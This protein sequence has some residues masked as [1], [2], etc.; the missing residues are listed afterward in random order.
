M[1]QSTALAAARQELA[2]RKARFL[3]GSLATAWPAAEPAAKREPRSTA[4]EYRHCVICTAVFVVRLPSK[5]RRKTCGDQCRD[6]HRRQLANA[7]KRNR[8]HA[9]RAGVSDITN[10]QELAMRRKARD[11]PLCQVAM[12]NDNGQPNSKHLD[13]ILP[14]NM[15]GTHTHGNVRII[16]RDCNLRRPRDGSDYTGQLTLWAQGEPA[17]KRTRTKCRKGLHQ[18]TPGNIKVVNGKQ[19][20]AACYQ[21]GN[22]ARWK[23]RTSRQPKAVTCKCGATFAAP[24]RT[25][26]CPA[27]T[28]AAAWKAAELHATGLTWEQVAPLVGYRSAWGAAYVAKRAAVV[29]K[30]TVTPA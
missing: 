12:T 8:E 21:A 15:G 6:E 22:S 18:W 11:C 10:E 29:P 19:R 1:G 28:G 2:A 16:C 20:C 4:I 7:R 26:M 9:Q 3:A 30:A 23:R 24:G 27:C 17:V 5:G 25:L 14:L 13:H